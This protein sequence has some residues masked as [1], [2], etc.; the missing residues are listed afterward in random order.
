[1]SDTLAAGTN[2][3]TIYLWKRKCISDCDEN[4]WPSVPESCAIHGTVKEL[5]WGVSL[6]RNSLLAVNCITNVFILHQQP[7]C[8]V[9]NDGI[10]ASQLTPTQI[11][12]EMDEQTYTLKTEIQVQVVAVTRKYVAISS[13]RQIV[14]NCINKDANLNTNVLATFN[15]DTEKLLIYEHTLIVLTPTIIQLRSIEGSIIQ[16]L[17]TLPEEGEP[18]TM[19]LTGNL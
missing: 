8:A 15:C 19:E 18:I 14:V 13:G 2:L 1:M 7:M 6:S 17:P 11:L 4:A 9:Y 10:C 16:T 12:L 3:G 5:T